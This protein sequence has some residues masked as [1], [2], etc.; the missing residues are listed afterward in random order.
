MNIRIKLAF[1]EGAA[2]RLL[3]WLAGEN[4]R[5]LRARPDLPLLY[6]TAVVYQ[7]ERDETWCD[8]LNTILHGKEDCDGL[9]AYRAGELIARGWRALRPGDEGYEAAVLAKPKS[10]P[11]EVF[12][13]TRVPVGGS[14]TY[15]CVVRYPVEG[16]WYSD[17]PS[18]RLGMHGFIGDDIKARRA[19]RRARRQPNG[20]S[21]PNTLRS[22]STRRS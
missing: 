21:A 1:H 17:D 8:V 20:S 19:K 13:R 6:D 12:L 11:A 9:S 5:I 4:A 22:R 3:N 10:I 7:R 15:H 14:G 16:A 18:A 2:V